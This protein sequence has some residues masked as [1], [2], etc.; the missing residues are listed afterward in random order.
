MLRR[1]EF[2]YVP[3]HA[4]W[5]N[6]L[7]IEIGVLVSQCL[8]R[9]IESRDQLAAE[10]AIWEQQRNATGARIKWISQP[11]RFAPNRAGLIRNL[12]STSAKNAKMKESKPLCP[13]TSGAPA[14]DQGIAIL[15]ATFMQ[16]STIMS[17]RRAY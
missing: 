5:L 13:G 16:A 6:M 10:T 17:H 11:K 4:S 12:R 2:H 14:L 8:D 9:R 3:K 1:L 7:E 15:D